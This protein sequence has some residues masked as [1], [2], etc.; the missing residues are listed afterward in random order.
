MTKRYISLKTGAVV[1]GAMAGLFAA[2][3]A[4][5]QK[6]EFSKEK[7][8][9]VKHYRFVGDH[10]EESMWSSGSLSCGAREA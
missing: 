1:A 7:K 10:R 3:T 6:I 2:S 8:A 5:A 4:F 9:V